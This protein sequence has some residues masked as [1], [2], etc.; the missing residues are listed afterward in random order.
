MRVASNTT[1]NAAIVSGNVPTGKGGVEGYSG[2]AE[3]FPRFLELWGSSH[4]FTDYG[5]MVEL[6][7]SQQ[8]TGKWGSGN[9]YDPPTRQ[10]FFDPNFKI[11]APPGT[12]MVYTY[13]KGRWALAP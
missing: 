2:G 4:T 9:V 6:Y 13:S 3:N 8:A 7:Q 1:V 11:N 10:W 12:L 5:S